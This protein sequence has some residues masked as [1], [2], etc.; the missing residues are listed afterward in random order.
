MSIDASRKVV[1]YK[2]LRGEAST[3]ESFIKMHLD[4][5]WVLYGNP[6][7]CVTGN[8]GHY[9]QAMVRYEEPSASAVK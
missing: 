8:S 6:Y 7:Y 5:G 4:I 2:N 3:L 9:C 1:D